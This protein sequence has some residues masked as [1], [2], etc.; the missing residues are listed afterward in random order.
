MALI[1]VFYFSFVLVSALLDICKRLKICENIYIL[2]ILLS[3][4]NTGFI[5]K[6]NIH[7]KT[8]LLYE[9]RF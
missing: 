1:S 7:N 5:E 2:F 6:L 9:S 8:T 3:A 4:V